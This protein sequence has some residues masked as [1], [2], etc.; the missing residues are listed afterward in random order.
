M[1]ERLCFRSF[2]DERNIKGDQ[3]E[4]DSSF[5]VVK[6]GREKLKKGGEKIS[7]KSTGEIFTVLQ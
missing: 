7:V 5:C 4:V 2:L 6:A 3:T 1:V